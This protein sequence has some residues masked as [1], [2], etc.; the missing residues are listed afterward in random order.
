[1]VSVPGEVVMCHVIFA[2]AGI[3]SNVAPK[4]AV[5]YIKNRLIST[6]DNGFQT[7]IVLYESA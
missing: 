2:A 3:N 4:K 7:G 1:M 6:T 5:D